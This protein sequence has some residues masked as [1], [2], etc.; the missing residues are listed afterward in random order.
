MNAAI[1][2]ETTVRYRRSLITDSGHDVIVNSLT[3]SALVSGYG[4]AA[5]VDASLRDS[6]EVSIDLWI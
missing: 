2:V 6:T 4:Q 3:L 1:S 5:D